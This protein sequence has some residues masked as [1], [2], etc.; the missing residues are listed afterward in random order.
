MKSLQA[1]LNESVNQELYAK[2]LEDLNRTK[3]YMSKLEKVEG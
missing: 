1:T 2:A 3:G